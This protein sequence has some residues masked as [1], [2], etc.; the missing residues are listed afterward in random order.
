MTPEAAPSDPI[1]ERSTDLT[2]SPEADAGQALRKRAEA[3]AAEAANKKRDRQ[4]DALVRR[5][6]AA[7]RARDTQALQPWCPSCRVEIV[8]FPTSVPVISTTAVATDASV[9]I[10]DGNI[11][12]IDRLLT[13]CQP[14]KRIA[15]RPSDNGSIGISTL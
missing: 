14:D 4:R 2:G 3:L 1:V 10:T 11:A 6:R 15:V 12:R 8:V 9:N 13:T 5:V 7:G